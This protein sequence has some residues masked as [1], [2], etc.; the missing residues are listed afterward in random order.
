VELKILTDGGDHFRQFLWQG[1]LDFFGAILCGC[2]GGLAI[3]LLCG[4]F[5]FRCAGWRSY[6]LFCRCD[7]LF[8]RDENRT[9]FIDP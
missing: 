4:G 2:I 5:L 1:E 3:A 8:L 7:V 9:S 6:W